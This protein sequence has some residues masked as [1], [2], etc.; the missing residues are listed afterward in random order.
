MLLRRRKK[1]REGEKRRE[2]ERLIARYRNLDF[3]STDCP[4]RAV[5][6][7]FRAAVF[8][9]TCSGDAALVVCTGASPTR[10]DDAGENRP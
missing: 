10:D 6:T 9:V 2:R 4:A 3:G 1:K 8:F 5:P 7:C